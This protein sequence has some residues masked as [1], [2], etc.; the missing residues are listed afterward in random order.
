MRI[1]SDGW[2]TV[3]GCTVY[4][5]NN[6]ILRGIRHDNNGSP[7]TVY[8]YRRIKDGWTSAPGVK[9]ETFRR[10]DRYALL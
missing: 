7:V 5:E 3:A 6:C 1:Y 2:H 4:V 8:P 9:A 10:S